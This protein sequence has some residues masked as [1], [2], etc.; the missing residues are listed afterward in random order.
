MDMQGKLLQPERLA[1]ITKL[2]EERGT[3]KVG[4]I[5]TRLRVSE[6]TV[7]RDLIE[8]ERQ[9][10]CQ[11]TKGGA[12]KTE[13][14][15]RANPFTRRHNQYHGDKHSIALRAAELVH[16]GSTIIIDSGT[17]AAELALQLTAKRHITVITPSLAAANVL[18]D[19][20][21][22]T[23]ILPGGV[24]NASSRS[25]TGS[26]AEDFFSS[27]HADILFLAVKAV[28][29]EGGLADH[30][31]AETAVKR[32]M[33]SCSDRVVV[34]AD[35]SKIGKTA[36]SKIAEIKQADTIITDSQANQQELEK[37]TR[38]GLTVLTAGR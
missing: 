13:D 34:L 14:R 19:I 30:N 22:I 1:E 36:L 15:Q 8:L 11:R 2:L 37:I 3:V 21:E 5:S 32:S 23:L 31:I 26:P 27:I 35:H 6:N 38:L 7:R 18:A 24:M 29:A 33:I 10:L 16:S 12:T 20:P 28:S 4:E 9:G 25:L 17:T